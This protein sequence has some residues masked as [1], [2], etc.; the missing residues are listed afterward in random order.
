MK[1]I[2]VFLA[3]AFF[4][5]GCSDD[6]SISPVQNQYN[7]IESSSSA[8]KMYCNKSGMCYESPLKLCANTYN[9][10]CFSSCDI[11]WGDYYD[12]CRQICFL[13]NGNVGLHSFCND[14]CQRESFLGW[15][16]NSLTSSSSSSIKSSSSINIDNNCYNQAVSKCNSSHIGATGVACNSSVCCRTSAEE[17]C[18]NP[19]RY[20]S[21]SSK[22]VVVIRSSS[23]SLASSSSKVELKFQIS[24]SSFEDTRDHQ[25]YKTVSYETNIWGTQTWMAQNLNYDWSSVNKT[26]VNSS[27]VCANPEARCYQVSDNYCYNRDEENCLKYGQLYKNSILTKICPEGWRIPNKK[28]YMILFAIAKGIAELDTIIPAEELRSTHDWKS[29]RKGNTYIGDWGVPYFDTIYGNDVNG[30]D[31]IGFAILPAGNIDMYKKTNPKGAYDE[32]KDVYEGIY[33]RTGLFFENGCFSINPP[34]A[35]WTCFA[36]NSVRCIKE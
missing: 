21:S 10:D 18:Q 28:D 25:I 19:S 16:I 5:I 33:G 4:V 8:E 11:A 34:Y 35:S 7:I 3:M 9:E 2:I 22:T 24:L 17:Y 20:P 31:I 12:L 13:K 32:Y 26:P 36:G 15:C 1:R 6:G 27:N 30:T 14:L 29:Y 23:S